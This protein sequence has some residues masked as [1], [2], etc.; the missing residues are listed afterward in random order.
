MIIGQKQEAVN[1]YKNGA[2][3]SIL[4]GG[5]AKEHAGKKRDE[6]LSVKGSVDYLAK[7]HSDAF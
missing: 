1:A 2:R 7:T 6:P 5:G 3:T 4:W